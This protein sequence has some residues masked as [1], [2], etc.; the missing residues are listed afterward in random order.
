MMENAGRALALLARHRFLQLDQ[1]NTQVSKV[2]V[3]AG[4]GGNGGGGLVAARRLHTWGIQ[5]EC[6]FR[7]KRGWAVPAQQLAILRKMEVPHLFF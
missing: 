2:A 6:C 1:L 4:S 3:L 7:M 5:V